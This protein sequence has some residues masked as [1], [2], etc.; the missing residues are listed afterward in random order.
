M[1]RLSPAERLV[2]DL[3]WNLLRVFLAIAEAGSI[4]GAAALLSLKQPS[5]S[6]A[7]KRLEARLGATLVER[8]PGHFRLTPAGERLRVE[9]EEVR[10]AVLRLSDAVTEVEGQ[11]SGP[12]TI[13]MASHVISPHFDRVI[14]GFHRD[15]PA[16]TFD[17][18]VIASRTAIGAVQAR[19]ASFAV[20]LVSALPPG[21]EAEVLYR[22]SFGLFCGPTHPLFGQRGVKLGDLAGLP[23]VSFR[24]DRVGDALQPVTEMRRAA[25]LDDRVVG[26]SVNLEEVRWMIWVGMGIGPLPLHIAA[27][28]VAEGRLWR[29]PP[30]SD[31][32]AIEV[33]LVWNPKQRLNSAEAELL[34][35][36]RSEIAQTPA[37]ERAY[38][39]ATDAGS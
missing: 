8:R 35:R 38:D 24:T 1:A 18:E 11:A 23:S 10:A 6:S 39:D 19:K 20:C 32:P 7:L 2:R 12:V 3:D 15:H 27:E 4:T 13:A 37:D 9:A 33:F 22:E 5:V 29:L 28:D 14:A 25:Q 16:A 34:A 30:Y 26:T 31:P 21:L 17:I 36:L